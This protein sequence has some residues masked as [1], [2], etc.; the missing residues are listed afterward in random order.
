MDT[1]KKLRSETGT[2]LLEVMIAFAVASIA[3]VSLITLVVTSMDVED[4]A[5]KVTEA[6]LIADDRLKDIERTGLPDLGTTEGVIDDEQFQGFSY[7][8]MVTETPIEQVRQI[9]IEIQWDKGRRSVNL[10]AFMAR[11]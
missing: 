4:H 11:P 1:L 8:L 6:T 9:D 2:T 5:R 3:L 10:M 7:R